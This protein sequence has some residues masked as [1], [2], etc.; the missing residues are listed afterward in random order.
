MKGCLLLVTK[1]VRE[2]FPLRQSYKTDFS[3]TTQMHYPTTVIKLTALA[4]KNLLVRTLDTLAILIIP[5]FT[6]NS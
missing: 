1:A 3:Q 6:A 2:A 4:N 5:R